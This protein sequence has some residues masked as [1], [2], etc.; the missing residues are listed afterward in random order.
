MHG[1]DFKTFSF[2]RNFSATGDPIV[3]NVSIFLTR[4]ILKTYEMRAGESLCVDLLED[5]VFESCIVKRT[6]SSFSSPSISA[7]I[8]VAFPSN[9]P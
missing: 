2:L 5:Q 8:W 1:I 9:L 3:K 7:Q 6:E 4:R